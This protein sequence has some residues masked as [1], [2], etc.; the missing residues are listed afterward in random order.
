MSLTVV[1]CV[2]SILGTGLILFSWV[3]WK[4]VRSKLRMLVVFL[5]VSDMVISSGNLLGSFMLM[6]HLTPG[7][8]EKYCEAQSFFTTGSSMVS[9]MFTMFIAIYL[10]LMVSKKTDAAVRLVPLATFLSIVIPLLIVSLAMAFGALGLSQYSSRIGWCWIAP[11]ENIYGP[12]LSFSGRI[13][14]WSFVAGKGV[15]M[16]AYLFTPILYFYIRR[17]M[18]AQQYDSRLLNANVRMTLQDTER[19]L[20]LI[21]FIFL[22]LRIWGSL[23]YVGTLTENEFLSCNVVLAALQGVGDSGQG[24]ANALLF[25][26]FTRKVRVK[27]FECLCT[28][29]KEAPQHPME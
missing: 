17:E 11:G 1:S 7:T 21:P 29:K 23:R 18:N 13:V 2:L 14:F 5:S 24:W 26:F 12:P 25:C 4:D 15:E 3:F 22:G 9:F 10:Y 19:K 28:C 6:A 8:F 27:I 16:T 20:V